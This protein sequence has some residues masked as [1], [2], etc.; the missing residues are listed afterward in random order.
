M[1]TMTNSKPDPAFA[2]TL[3]DLLQAPIRWQLID[4]GLTLD[5]FDRLAA[6]R[7]AGDLAAEVG[8]DAARLALVLDALCAMGAVTKTG[9]LYGLTP[10][11][12][13]YLTSDGAFSV[14]DMLVGLSWLRHSTV[15][16]LLRAETPPPLDMSDPAFWDR[17]VANLRSFHRSMGAAVM[18][19]CL[20]SLPVW[21]SARRMLDLGAGSEVLARTVAERRPDMAVTLVDLPPPAARITEALAGAGLAERVNVRVGDYNTADLGSGYDIAWAS[22]TLYYARDLEALC[23]R[24]REALAPGGV[25]VSLHEG[26]TD[27]RTQPESHVVGRLA[28]ALRGQDLSFNAGRIADA[29]RGAGF[30]GVDS[31]PVE[32][33]FGSMWLDVGR[34][35]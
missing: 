23:R 20:E 3:F 29:M 14:R 22:M 2:A 6:P 1:K 17:S 5:L 25:F 13:A 32:T 33:P 27:D 4:L 31:R 12:A 19:D 30:V 11:G 18:I 8:V 9:G 21:P 7:S 16:D 26:L 10:N 15:G 24:V 28:T 34:T 35:A